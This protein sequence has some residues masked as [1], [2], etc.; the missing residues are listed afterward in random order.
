MPDLTQQRSRDDSE[1][2]VRALQLIDEDDRVTEIPPHIEDTVLRAWDARA[3]RTVERQRFAA[4][5]LWAAALAAA[6]CL[7]FVAALWLP[8]TDAPD[9]MVTATDEVAD[10]FEVIATTGVLLHDDP[11]SLQVV[12]MSVE[13][14]VLAA[15]GYPLL[16]LTDTQ[17]VNVD[18]LIG[19]DGVARAIRP[20]ESGGIWRM[21]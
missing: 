1:I 19:L 3:V 14:S 10:P 4:R 6:A 17:P 2:V 12:R 9:I 15:Y 11:A 13:P 20:V 5:H 18:V 7:I 21:R 8:R 16:S